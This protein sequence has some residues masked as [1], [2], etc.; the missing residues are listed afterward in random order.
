MSI[1]LVCMQLQTKEAL[2]AGSA[3][4]T[5]VRLKFGIKR[6]LRYIVVKI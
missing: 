2:P 1:S 4:I 5:A 3:V 6:H